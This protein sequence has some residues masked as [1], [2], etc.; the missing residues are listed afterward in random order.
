[1]YMNVFDI[2]RNIYTKKKSVP[3]IEDGMLIVI[4]KW[5]SWDKDN[6]YALKK[7][8]KYLFYIEPL[9]YYYLLYFNI[10]KLPRAPFLKKIDEKKKEDCEL[11]KRIQYILNW[12]SSELEK[13]RSVLEQT[14]LKEPSYWKQE[15]GL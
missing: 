13:N 2:L 10:R 15:V 4:N 11:T 7:I 9:H 14:I 6:I 3:D 8:L 5:L 12:S 1:M